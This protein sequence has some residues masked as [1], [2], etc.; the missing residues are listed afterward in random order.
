MRKAVEEQKGSS[1]AVERE[2][3]RRMELTRYS[4]TELGPEEQRCEIEYLARQL[5][6]VSTFEWSPYR[7][8][9]LA[10]YQKELRR[11]VDMARREN[12]IS[13]PK[14]YDN[15]RDFSRIKNVDLQALASMMLGQEGWP[16]GE[17]MLFLC[18]WHTE[19]S[20]SLT[21]YPPGRGFYCFGCGRGGQDAAAFVAAVQKVS[22]VAAFDY[23]EEVCDVPENEEVPGARREHSSEGN[24][25]TVQGV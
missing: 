15:P 4:R 18:P 16:S 7:D 5:E 17:N 24:T 21:V 22:M 11:M 10:L 8:E 6:Y 12:G 25:G 3:L 13:T 1:D 9:T 23:I 2:Q 19:D 14:K 20:P